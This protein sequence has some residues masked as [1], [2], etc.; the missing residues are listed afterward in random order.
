VSFTYGPDGRIPDIKLHGEIIRL[1][2]REVALMSRLAAWQ[3]LARRLGE[4][5]RLVDTD[6]VCPDGLCVPCTIA[7]EALAELAKMEGER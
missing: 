6:C 2:W 3:S 5:S 4:A 1:R 7:Q